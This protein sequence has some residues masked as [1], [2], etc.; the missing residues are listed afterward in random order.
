MNPI[1]SLNRKIK[2][3]A[4]NKAIFPNDQVLIKQLSWPLKRRQR[5]GTS[6]TGIG[7]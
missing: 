7:L 1:E 4:K 3:V 6:A 5:S 2:T